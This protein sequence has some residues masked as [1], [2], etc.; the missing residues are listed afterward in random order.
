MIEYD[1][2]ESLEEKSNGFIEL[3]QTIEGINDKKKALWLE[4]YNNANRDR[5]IAYSLYK[6]LRDVAGESSSEYAIHG[7][8]I[9]SYLERMSKANDQ[10]LKLAE[11]VANAER[12]TGKEVDTED[13]F[14]QIG[15]QRKH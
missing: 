15:G 5:Q 4:I 2:D 3:L 14:K 1:S 8:T 12:K 7:K 10:L 6:L 11:L 9:T 13:I